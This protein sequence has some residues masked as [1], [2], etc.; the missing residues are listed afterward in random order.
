[1]LPLRL[2][3]YF[4]DHIHA[5]RVRGLRDMNLRH[6]SRHLRHEISLELLAFLLLGKTLAQGNEFRGVYNKWLTEPSGILL[7]SI[8]SS[9][10]LN[11]LTRTTSQ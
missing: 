7:M 11:A 10:S 5:L 2:L 4:T 8:R 3:D 1:M 6:C 9:V